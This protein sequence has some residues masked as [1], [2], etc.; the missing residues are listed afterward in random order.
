MAT[1]LKAA[2]AREAN[3]QSET[4]LLDHDLLDRMHALLHRGAPV[5]IGERVTAVDV[6]NAGKEGAITAQG[7]GDTWAV[8]FD[9]GTTA[10]LSLTDLQRDWVTLARS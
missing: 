2:I 6:R 9:D 8:S 1:Q 5:Q 10:F 7:A 4:G 3:R